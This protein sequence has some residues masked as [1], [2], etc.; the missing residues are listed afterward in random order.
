[1]KGRNYTSFDLLFELVKVLDNL[2]NNNLN[3]KVLFYY[4]LIL[5]NNIEKEL[6]RCK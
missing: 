2:K 3:Y 4:N 1:M 5:E 6:L